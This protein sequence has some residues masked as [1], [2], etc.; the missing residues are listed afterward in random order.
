MVSAENDALLLRVQNLRH[1]YGD[2]EILHGVNLRMNTGDR[3][4]VMGPSGSGKSTFL[5]CLGGIDRPNEGSI[6]FDGIE[7]TSLRSEELANLRRERISTIF[8]FFHLLPTLTVFENIEFPLQLQG[9]AVDERVERAN[10]LVNQV[11][12][13]H[14]AHAFPDELSGGE[15]QRV[16]IARALV[17]RPKLLLADEPTGNLDVRTG[18]EILNTLEALA[19][20]YQTALV[21]VTHSPAATRICQ[22][23]EHFR[24]GVLTPADSREAAVL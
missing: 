23:I 4:A 5:N 19:D 20:E 8:Q 15:M 18:E 21:L 17:H 16:A 7:L 6:Q 12:L 13:E 11:D 22:R 24:D 10:K 9:V 2:T 3:V 14:R 1:S